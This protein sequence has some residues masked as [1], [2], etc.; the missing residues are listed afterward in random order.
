M[1]TKVFQILTTV[2]LL[3]FYPNIMQMAEMR[4]ASEITECLAIEQAPVP[5]Q[6]I[7]EVTRAVRKTRGKRR[8]NKKIKWT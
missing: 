2:R 7:K 1:N 6:A 5:N 4:E 3:I 8:L